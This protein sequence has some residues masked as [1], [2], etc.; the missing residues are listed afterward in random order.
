MALP[1]FCGVLSE[2]TKSAEFCQEKCRNQSG[3]TKEFP[4]KGKKEIKK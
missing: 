2:V 1:E 4:G 3:K